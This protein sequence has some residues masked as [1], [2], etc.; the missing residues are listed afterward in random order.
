MRLMNHI[1]GTP[2]KA[3]R[4]A[5]FRSG[6]RPFFLLGAVWAMVALAVFILAF[7]GTMEPPQ[8]AWDVIAWHRHE[9][10]F[11]FV[12]AIIAGFLFTAVPNWTGRPTP[13]GAV[14][15]AIVGLWVAGRVAVTCSAHLS[16]LLVAAVDVSFFLA[17]AAG[18]APAL[19]QSKN[20]RNYVFIVLL[21]LLAT[22]NVLTHM[23]NYADMGIRLALAIVTMMMVIIGGRVIPFFTERRLG[24][25]I[26][27]NPRIERL[28][29]VATVAALLL[30]VVA[31]NDGWT[32]AAFIAAAVLNGWRWSQWQGMKTLCVPLLWV[33]HAAYLWLAA[34]F[35][36]R[37]GALLELGVPL[38]AATH[39]LTAGAMAGLILGMIARV[40]LGHSGR[41]LEIGR[42][43]TAAFLCINA[44]AFIRVFGVW[45]F[46]T[47]TMELLQLA[48]ILW[49]GAFGMFLTVYTPILLRPRMDRKDG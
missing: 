35:L 48:A 37:A 10:L 47:L 18:V 22:A 4:M 45:I 33:L 7:S 42:A 21:A 5:L 12:G 46:P 15:A 6:F 19:I 32:G 24:I 36:L 40:S 16:A 27:R 11:G 28:T 43:M 29:L 1:S 34:S 39:A 20:R 41:P 31:F 14:L 17:C 44:T 9:M 3:P 25:A 26:T 8:S 30:D 38:P 2:A 23:E 49:L 13:K